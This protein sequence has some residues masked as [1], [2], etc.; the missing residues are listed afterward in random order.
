MLCSRCN[1]RPAVVF[2]SDSS[3]NNQKGYCL[4]CA[5]ELNIKPIKDIMKTM[6][7]TE[8]HSGFS[9]ERG[10]KK[11]TIKASRPKKEKRNPNINILTLIAPI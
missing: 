3:G 4:S 7:I 1:K 10:R 2:V 6:G 9:V 11:T 5:N 8:E